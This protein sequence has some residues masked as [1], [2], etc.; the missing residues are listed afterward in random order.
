MAN[1]GILKEYNMKITGYALLG[2]AVLLFII[3][4][5]Y[6]APMN[7]TVVDK[8]TGEPIEG[9]VALVDWDVTI[10]IGFSTTTAYKMAERLTDKQ[11]WFV[12]PGVFNPFVNPPT[13]VIYKKGYIAW[14]SDFIF[15]G[16]EKKIFKW[17]NTHKFEMEKFVRGYSH[18]HHESFIQSGLTATTAD[19]KLRRA[20]RWESDLAVKENSLMRKKREQTKSGKKTGKELWQEVLEE[21][22][23]KKK[24][25]SDE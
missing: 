5:R 8:E 18:S 17:R 6:A 20:Y 1:F 12:L 25:N 11:G 4:T 14:R 13:V 19:S 24:G 2:F 10:S 7:G 9:A 21:L 3:C 16:Y 22:Y 15:P 23:G